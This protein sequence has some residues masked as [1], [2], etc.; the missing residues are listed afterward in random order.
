L[1]ALSSNY[2]SEVGSLGMDVLIQTLRND[3]EDREIVGDVLTT[4]NCI[5]AGKA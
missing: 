5:I 3:K 2:R 4:L 1:R